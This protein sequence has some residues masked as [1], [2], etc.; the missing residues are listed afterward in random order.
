MSEE[1][2]RAAVVAL[3]ALARSFDDRDQADAGRCLASF[4]EIPEAREPL[5][6]LMLGSAGASAVRATV[7][8]LLRRQD[9][10]GVTVVAAALGTADPDQVD[11]I[12]IALADVMR[13]LA[14]ELDLE[15]TMRSCGMLVEGDDEDLSRGADMLISMVAMVSIMDP[16][17]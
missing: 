7:E 3:A 17:D 9:A 1:M 16:D 5:W 8:G 12:H 15:A 11:R 2:R 10:V 14:G 6:H 13:V 4:A